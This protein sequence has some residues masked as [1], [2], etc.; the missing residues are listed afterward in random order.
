MRTRPRRSRSLDLSRHGFGNRLGQRTFQTIHS[1]RKDRLCDYKHRISKGNR[2]FVSKGGLDG[3]DVALKFLG[4][5]DTEYKEPLAQADVDRFKAEA[6]LGIRKSNEYVVRVLGYCEELHCI[7]MELYPYTLEDLLSRIDSRTFIFENPV[8]VLKKGEEI[9][10]ALMSFHNQE[11][12][13]AHGD[14]HPGN[15]FLTENHSVRVGDFEQAAMGN[16]VE[17]EIWQRKF[18][19]HHKTCLI[20]QSPEVREHSRKEGVIRAT[21]ASDVFSLGTILIQM[22][23]KELPYWFSKLE[24]NFNPDIH[25]KDELPSI[26]CKDLHSNWKF[27]GQSFV[28]LC[29]ACVD[30]NPKKRPCIVS[31]YKQLRSIRLSLEDESAHACTKCAI[32]EAAKDHSR[33]ISAFLS[34]EYPQYLQFDSEHLSPHDSLTVHFVHSFP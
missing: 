8:I 16:S 24:S 5:H 1:I 26:H 19:W 33:R 28:D 30:E 11:P 18:A 34:R 22:A 14:L 2:S 27:Y 23:I 20:Y 3:R 15:V 7:V 9:C 25:L 10:C 21:P 12:I 6:S 32:H 17:G 29:M 13:C 4:R 31:L